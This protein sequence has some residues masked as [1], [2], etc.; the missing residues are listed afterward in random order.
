MDLIIINHLD[1]TG[2]AKTMAVLIHECMHHYLR[3]RG[4]I[5]QDTAGN[6][7]LTEVFQI[8]MK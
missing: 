8:Q 6:E 2:Y 1:N 7:Y 5:L 4:I 3:H